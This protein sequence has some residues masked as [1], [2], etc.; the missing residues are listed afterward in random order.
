MKDVLSKDYLGYRIIT[1]AES[2]AMR[3]ASRKND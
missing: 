3:R 1:G 2:D